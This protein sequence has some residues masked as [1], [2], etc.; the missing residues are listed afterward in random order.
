MKYICGIRNAHLTS[1]FDWPFTVNPLLKMTLSALRK[2]WP[3]D[4]TLHKVPL[5]LD[6]LLALCRSMAGWPHFATLAFEDLTW[7]CASSM[8]FFAALRGGEFF[9][10]P[11]SSRPTLLRSAVTPVV[12]DGRRFLKIMVPKPKTGLGLVSEAAFAASPG[13]GHEFDPVTLWKF[14]DAMRNVVLPACLSSAPSCP[15]F[16][17]EDGVAISRTFMVG[18]ANALCCEAGIKVFDSEGN[19]IPITA[20]SWRA[21]FVLSARTADVDAATIRAVGRWGSAAGP[22]PYTFDSTG[23][24]QHASR[25]I[26]SSSSSGDIGGVRSASFAGGSF[27]SS[28]VV[29]LGPR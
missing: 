14:Y 3:D 21:G 1:G 13:F 4:D 9:T 8:A 15:A 12:G 5:S 27:T 6:I 25:L 11:T 16:C 18:K 10:Y 2:K 24:I 29:E 22:L 26:A 28:S 7:A 17:L 23:S 19:S 20:A